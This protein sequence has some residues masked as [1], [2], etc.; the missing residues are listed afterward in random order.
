M[1]FAFSRH[2]KHSVSNDRM[3]LR[4]PADRAKTPG[5]TQGQDVVTNVRE[6][7]PQVLPIKFNFKRHENF[8]VISAKYVVSSKIQWSKLGK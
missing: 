3:A 1:I 4:K 2:N 5:S 6:L 8:E 7:G